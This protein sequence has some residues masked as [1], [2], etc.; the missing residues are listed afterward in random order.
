MKEPEGGWLGLMIRVASESKSEEEFEENLT[1][2]L[3]AH[4][5]D[6]PIR[7][8]LGR[9]SWVDARKMARVPPSYRKSVE[10]GFMLRN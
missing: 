9:Y 2:Q 8:L 6:E 1:K 5:A 7:D 10:R 4:E 3:D